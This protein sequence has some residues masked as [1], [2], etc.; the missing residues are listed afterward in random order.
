MEPPRL[1]TRRQV[2]ALTACALAAPSAVLAQTPRPALL[3]P[4]DQALVDRA[5]AYLQGLT[6]AKGRFTQT[7]ARGSVTAGDLFLKRPGKARFAYDP[8]SGLLVVSDG[9]AVAIQDSR[10]KTFDSYPLMATPLSLFLAKTIR[11]DRGVQVTH[12]ARAADGFSVTARDGKKE[13]AGQI[14]LSFTDKPM[15]LR[16][17]AVTDAQGRTVQVRVDQLEPASGLS[18]SLFVLRDPRPKNVGRGKL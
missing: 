1:S 2:L 5:V 6:E 10:L 14:T 13:T 3:S 9:G 7:D 15:A 17:W 11:L 18:P 4:D 12:V 8:P 16:G